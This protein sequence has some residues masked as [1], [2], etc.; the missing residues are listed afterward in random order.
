M[1]LAKPVPFLSNRHRR[2]S[3]KHGALQIPGKRTT[4]FHLAGSEREGQRDLA[5][6]LGTYSAV[7]SRAVA[8][9]GC[10]IPAGP[11]AIVS[12]LSP[13]AAVRGYVDSGKAA[14]RESGALM[15]TE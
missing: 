7:R 1:C 14:A 15:E 9:R 3:K 5:S 2:D 10:G 12:S 6:V 8:S 13:V 4:L 11:R